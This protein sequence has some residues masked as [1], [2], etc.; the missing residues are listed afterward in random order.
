MGFE[1]IRREALAFEASMSAYSI[2]RA[3]PQHMDA[4]TE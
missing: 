1:P 3:K 4:V 2:T